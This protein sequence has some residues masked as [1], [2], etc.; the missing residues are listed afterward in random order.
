MYPAKPNAEKTWK[1]IEDVLANRLR[2]SVTDRAVYYHLLRH[3]RLEGKRQLKFSIPQLELALHKSA[4]PV[5]DSVRR[6]VWRRV[7][8][9]ICISKQGYVVEVRLPHEVRAVRSRLSHLA[10]APKPTPPVNIENLDFFI[11][12]KLRKT[13]HARES[14]RCFYCMRRT[15]QTVQCLDHVIPQ[16]RRGHNSY[17]NLVSCCLECNSRKGQLQA[18]KFLRSLYRQGHLTAR[19]LSS[20]LLALQHLAS[21]K[22]IPPLS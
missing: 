5:R 8:R 1:Q 11:S 21:G 18:A 6:L 2:L 10:Q 12:K 9:V 14:G 3:S 22:L 20:R 16:V 15:P 13:I 19:E 4:R 17:R 7:L